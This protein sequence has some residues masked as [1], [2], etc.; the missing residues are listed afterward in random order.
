MKALDVKYR[1]ADAGRRNAKGK[2]I[3]R[4]QQYAFCTAQSMPQCPI[5]CLPEIYALGMLLM[6]TA[7][8]QGDFHIGNGRPAQNADMLRFLQMAQN[9]TLPV[10]VQHLILTVTFKEQTAS[11]RQGLQKKMH[12]CIMTQRLIMA[13]PLNCVQYR[14]L[15]YNTA[16]IKVHGGMIT[17]LYGML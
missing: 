13:N 8:K 6:G 12:L 1:T 3:V 9:K 2:F 10:T 17:L 11:S 4:L 7:A 15:I 14:F 5:G 16:L